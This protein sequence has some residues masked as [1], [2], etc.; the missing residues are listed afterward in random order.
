MYTA[1]FQIELLG[2]D[3]ETIKEPILDLTCGDGQLVLYLRELELEAYGMDRGCDKRS[4]Y[5]NKDYYLK[6]KLTAGAY[7][8]IVSSGAFANEFIRHFLGNSDMY[9]VYGEKYLEI[10]AALQ[11]GGSF[12]YA[13]TLPM[14]ENLLP[15]DD[16]LVEKTHLIDDFYRTVVTK[17]GTENN[18]GS[19]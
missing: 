2:L 16:Y 7:G 10:L 6:V 15:K 17:L 8:T 3:P 11:P 9:R 1:E 13:P 12:H 18:A 5:L 19:E 14:I 4:P